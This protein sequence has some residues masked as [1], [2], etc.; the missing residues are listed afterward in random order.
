MLF[1]VR[2]WF[3]RLIHEKSFKL[4]SYTTEI[5]DQKIINIA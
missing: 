2:R 1:F 4:V 3:W 5:I